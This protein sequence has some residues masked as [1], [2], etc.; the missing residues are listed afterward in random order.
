MG[1]MGMEQAWLIPAIPAAAFVVLLLF[2][3]YL[4][5]RGDWVAIGAAAASFVLFFFVLSDLLDKL[6]PST[7]LRTAGPDF[8]GRQGW[9]W[10]SF[11]EFHLRLGFQVDQLTV[12]MLAVVTFVGLMVQVYSTG[13]MRGGARHG[14]FFPALSLFVASM[15]TLVLADN[16]LL[17][18]AA[19]EGVGFCSYL[20]IGF[21]HER[22][23]AAEAAKKAF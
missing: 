11:G 6:D 18:Y 15:L 12:V 7:G 21:W 23:S 1:G 14:W 9:D 2:G 4:P 19:W 13:Y 5:R 3:K 10:V 8:P 20:L 17:L 16:F 22:R